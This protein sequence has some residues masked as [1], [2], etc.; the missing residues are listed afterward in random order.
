MLLPEDNGTT[1]ASTVLTMVYVKP[2]IAAQPS[3]S[4][5]LRPFGPNLAAITH[6]AATINEVTNNGTRK[7]CILPE[8][9]SKLAPNCPK[10]AIST[11]WIIKA[12]KLPKSEGDEMPAELTE[13]EFVEPR[14]AI[15]KATNEETNPTA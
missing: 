14:L 10:L 3:R 2:T 1:A 11:S 12:T 13:P 4:S 15:S 6:A 7:M 9:E 8:T 5:K